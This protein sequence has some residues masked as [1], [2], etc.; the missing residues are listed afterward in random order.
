[1]KLIDKAQDYDS[2]DRLNQRKLISVICETNKEARDYLYFLKQREQEEQ[3]QLPKTEVFSI[4]IKTIMEVSNPT[5]TFRI[6]WESISMLFIF[7]QMIYIPMALSFSIDSSFEMEIIN[8]IMDIFFVVDMLLNFRLA[9]YENGKLEYRLKYIALNYL[10]LWFWIDAIAVLPFDLMIGTDSNQSTQIL[11]FVRLF[12]FVKIIRLLRV[13]KL[14][15]ILIKIEETFSIEQTLQAI[16]QFLKITAMILCIAHWI[17]CIWNIIEFVDEQVELTWMT[18]YGIHD[19]PWEVKYITAFYFSITTMITVGYGDISPNTNLEM[20]F[21][22]IVMVLSSGVFGFSMSSLNF[23]IQG[24]DQNIA[25]IKEQNQKIVK[26]IKQKNIPK[27][28]QI[29]VKNYL[30]WLEGSAQVAKNSQMVIL[31]NLSSNLHTEVLTLLH[32]RILKQVNLIS[33]EFSSQLTNKLIYVLKEHLLG[34]EEYVFKENQVDSNLLYFIQNGQVDICLTRREFSLKLLN[35]G[36][37]FGEIS[38]FSKSPR[39]AS[40]KTLD[41]VNLMSLSRKDLWEQAQDLNSDLEKLFYIKNCVDVENSLKPLRLRCYICD[42]PHHIARNCTIM[43]FRV[44]RLKVIEEYLKQKNTRIKEFKRRNGKS[45]ISSS[46]IIY[47]KSDAVFR[48]RFQ[49]LK[50]IVKTSQQIE[51]LD[52]SAVDYSKLSTQIDDN[53]FCLDRH[54]DYSEFYTEFNPTKIISEINKYSEQKLQEMREEKEQIANRFRQNWMNS[55]RQKQLQIAPPRQ[56]KLSFDA[57]KIFSSDIQHIIFS[58]D[59]SSSHS[60]YNL[61]TKKSVRGKR[62]LDI[63]TQKQLLQDQKINI[64]FLVR[65]ISTKEVKFI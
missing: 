51:N 40:A 43:H 30:E 33:R 8:D 2:N 16:I 45:L 13:L 21:G 49:Q 34:P 27:T 52:E 5:S 19:A 20:I 47:S 59:S 23:I 63:Q 36:D 22:I 7:V 60:S 56:S 54:R 62:L 26:Y 12:K 50:Q 32:G 61:L 18:Q 31:N 58:E 46:Q 3:Q 55:R 25:E 38:F 6:I 28:L 48:Y 35:K 29:R 39:T 41:F 64:S 4:F 17:A 44:R 53:N 9:Y 24:E 1:M 42:R 15:R 65:K 14:G 37:Y 57:Q 10:K 11:K